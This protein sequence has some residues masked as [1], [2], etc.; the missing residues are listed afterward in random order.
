MRYTQNINLPIVEDND[1]YSKEINNLAFEKIDEEIQGLV[2][3][4]ENLDSPENSIADIK[5]DIR[6]INEQLDNVDNEVNTLKNLIQSGG[7]SSGEGLTTE[8]AQQLQ[9]AY[10]HSQS[11]HVTTD[12]VS[13]AVRSYVNSNIG[14][15]KGDKGDKGEQGE[16]GLQGERGPQGLKGDKGD[17]GPQGERGL[18]GEVGPQGLKGDKGDNGLTPNITIGNVTTLDPSQ[19]AT[20]IRRGTD[21]NPIFDFG[22]PKGEKGDIGSGGSGGVSNNILAKYVHVGN[23]EIHLTNFDISTGIFTCSEPHNLTKNTL[24]I[25]RLKTNGKFQNIPKECFL[26]RGELTLVPQTSTTFTLNGITFNETNN[27]KI[28]VSKFYFECLKKQRLI[29]DFKE[30]VKSINV[31]I[32]GT[33]GGGDLY[34]CAYYDGFFN[35]A[36]N[37]VGGGS[38]TYQG[39]TAMSA[40]ATHFNPRYFN[41]FFNMSIADNLIVTNGTITQ[42]GF[43][44][45]RAI[46]NKSIAQIGS[47][48]EFF[49]NSFTGLCIGSRVHDWFY[50]NGLTIVVEKCGE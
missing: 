41:I 44:T 18:Q 22:I 26:L 31:R 29:L 36:S 43:G 4:V 23:Q 16:R 3:I 1:L 46:T 28:D 9:T 34:T 7:S 49:R 21:E 5:S 32:Y 47:V 35:I 38:G 15:L 37:S 20:V 40:N 42:I 24:V 2:D 10:E 8:Q 17:A 14:L 19:N 11:P 27:D 30:E 50:T 25:P 33:T 48:V 45:N 39:A 13:M 12:D 6:D